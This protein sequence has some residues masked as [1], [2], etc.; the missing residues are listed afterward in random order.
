MK[1]SKE[2]LIKIEDEKSG[3]STDYFLRFNDK[4]LLFEYT[5][6]QNQ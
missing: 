1:E 4:F 3:K 5:Y 6:W 2:K